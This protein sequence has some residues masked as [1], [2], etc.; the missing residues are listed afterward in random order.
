[1]DEALGATFERM[2]RAR[3]YA[4]RS[5]GVRD[6]VREAVCAWEGDQPSGEHCV[7][8]LSYIYDRRIRSLGERLSNL[9][10][11]HHDLV[12]STTQ[13][14][15]DHDHSFESVMLKGTAA[16]VRAFADRLRAERGVRFGALNLIAVD[17]DDHHPGEAPHSHSGHAHL[18][19][20]RG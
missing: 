14:R 8:N 2:L 7:A 15:L 17:P 20:R 10:H 13:V 18:S 6:V 19:P 9:Q 11:D 5:E 1:M 4:S 16:A 12:V 3:G